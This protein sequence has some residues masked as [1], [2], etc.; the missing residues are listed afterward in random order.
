ML[1]AA[2]PAKAALGR[3][4][5]RLFCFPYAGGN[6]STYQSWPTSEKVEVCPVELPGRQHRFAEPARARMEDL[7]A[8]LVAELA[9]RLTPPFALFGHSMGALIAYALTLELRRRDLPAPCHLLVSGRAA[10]QLPHSARTLHQ[11]PDAVLLRELGGA[12]EGKLERELLGVMLPTLRADVA[13]CETYAP[14]AEPPLAL[15]IAAFR[16]LWDGAVGRRQIEA[17]RAQT[18]GD[19]SMWEFPGGHQYLAHAARSL[20]ATIAGLL[21][22]HA[23]QPL[24]SAA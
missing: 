11:L 3:A 13:L 18:R 2:P 12:A 8:L 10:P 14:P 19:F 4:P 5:V 20:V 1:D 17:W 15:P 21:E 9:P 24:G 16:G 7:V 22:R 6:G 23:V